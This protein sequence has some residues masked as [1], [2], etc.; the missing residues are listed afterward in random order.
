LD[1]G[2]FLAIRDAPEMTAPYSFE[3]F[4]LRPATRELIVNGQPA[5]LGGRAFDVL[6][7]LVE[8]HQRL[9]TKDELLDLVW[10]GL[11]VE[12]NNLQVQISALRKILGDDVI[13]TLPGHGYR[14]IAQPVASGETTPAAYRHNLPQALTRFIGHDADLADYEKIVIMG[15][16][17]TLTGAGG[18]GKT[19][20]AIEVASRVLPQFADGAWFVDLAPMTDPKR[21]PATVA[22]T[23]GLT[24]QPD[25]PILEK[26]CEHV[27]RQ[28]MLLVL[29]NCEHLIDACA[30][31][32]TTMLGRVGA[33]HII[34]TSREA[35]G[36]PGEQTVTVRSLM[37][38]PVELHDGCEGFAR[39]EAVQLFVDRARLVQPAFTLDSAAAPVVGEICRRLDGIPL[40]IELA[41]ARTKVRSVGELRTMLDD[42]F[43]LLIGG[44]RT[45][46]PRQQ[47]LH[48]A[49]KWSFD[50]LPSD[51]R[52]LLEQLSIF[53]GGWT[54]AGAVAVAGESAG[55]YDVLERLAHLV[56]KS[57]VASRI[58][59]DITRY[60]M[61]ETVRQYGRE[62]LAAAGTE[63]AALKHHLEYFVSLAERLDPASN[64]SG[65]TDAMRQ[66]APELENFVQALRGCGRVPGGAALGLRL[67]AA[68]G[69]FWL[70]LGLVELGYRLTRETLSIQGADE[71]SLLRARS[72]FLATRLADFSGRDDEAWNHGSECLA[73]A[74]R[75]HDHHIEAGTLAMISGSAHRLGD[76]ARGIALAEEGLQLAREHADTEQII[77][78]L[79]N[80]A[81]IHGQ[82]NFDLS[83]P[84]LEESLQMCREGRRLPNLGIVACNL[85][86]T[87]ILRGQARL[88]WLPALEALDA[89]CAT[90][91]RFLM[92][93]VL[94]TVTRLTA[95][96]HDWPTAV[97]LLGAADAGVKVV[98]RTR[99][100]P[101]YWK[102][103]VDAIRS[104]LPDADFQTGY[105]AGRALTIEQAIGEARSWLENSEVVK[106]ADLAARQAAPT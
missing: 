54:L 92:T 51:E 24:E 61:L 22:R 6:R 85:A 87:Q 44:S 7:V 43:R 73:L 30:E 84:L 19:R 12:E 9:V 1:D 16:L 49:I 18:C 96:I 38:P 37:C 57:L 76:A 5:A 104:S 8:R 28:Q 91:S 89:S 42:R 60:S 48:A 86:D 94:D 72:L 78:A 68:L 63:I 13:K 106:S 15:R 64:D 101:H 66:L 3:R 31:L 93:I 23:L 81:Y 102:L 70:R 88:A 20:L 29:D 74:R 46:P 45:A 67:A 79:N 90:N 83:V 82:R 52:K 11:V 65:E 4:E 50:L 21:L 100:D 25:Q 10:P 55:Q 75:F 98:G 40:A 97:R 32:V 95:A 14:L 99:W 80:L 53:S 58:E 62:A 103:V 36:L 47:T 35:M 105:D 27:A 77:R 41:A 33:L 56:D 69:E 59:G 26:L 17:V 39:F 2:G 34:A 71:P